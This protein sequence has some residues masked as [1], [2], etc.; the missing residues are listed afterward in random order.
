MLK[1]LVLLIAALALVAGVS[2][3]ERQFNKHSFLIVA[4]SDAKISGFAGVEAD[5]TVCDVM[6]CETNSTN[7]KGAVN[8][9]VPISDTSIEVTVTPIDPELCPWSATVGL[10][11]VA[12]DGFMNHY[13]LLN[14][15]GAN[16]Q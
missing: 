12:E 11:G 2:A 9:R 3:A 6:G 10:S 14:E 16:A 5:V 7:A 8:F 1:T 15:C 4:E 13:V